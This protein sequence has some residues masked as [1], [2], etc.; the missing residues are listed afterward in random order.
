MRVRPLL[1]FAAI[2]AFLSMP[3]PLREAGARNAANP[4]PAARPSADLID[5]DDR[6]DVNNLD[7]VVTNHGSIAYDLITGNG[8]LVFPKGSAH[9]AVFAAGLWVGA[10]V[11]GGIRV[12]LGEYSQEYVPGPM[13][14]GTYL[15]DQDAF[16]NFRFTRG[17]PLTGSDLAEYVVQGGPTDASGQALLFGDAT[18]WSAFND[19]NP[20]M[21]TNRAGS[22]APL[23]IEVQ[24]TVFAFNRAGPLGNVIFV[25]WKLINKGG[26]RLDST[27]VS[28]WSDPDLGGFTDDLVGCDTTLSLGYCYN[29]TNTDGVYGSRPPA[30]GFELLRGVVVPRAPG[31]F[32]T[33]GMTSFIKY[34][35][36]TDPTSPEETYNYM[37][38]R[39]ADG[40]AMHVLI[41]SLPADPSPPVTL[42]AVSGLY[43]GAPRSS[44][45]WL[46]SNPGDRRMTL[47]S[48]PFTMAPG[49]SQEIVFAICIG[50]GS[51]RL[52]SIEDMRA[53]AATARAV[54]PLPP[55][56]PTLT[57]AVSID[58]QTIN[59]HS[60]APWVSATVEP[61]GFD[62][63]GI[64]LSS[65]LLAGALHAE[66]KF[67]TVGDHDSD[68]L[69]D[70]TLKFA[71]QGL[72]PLLVLGVNH[73]PLTGSLV[74]GEQFTGTA[75]VRVIDPFGPGLSARVSPNPLNPSG[76]L[77]FKT[78][79]SG[80][81]T[82]K[83]F[84]IRGRLVRSLMDVSFLPAG[85][86]EAEF[87]G[88]DDGGRAVASGIYIYEIETLEG[89]VAGRV[90]VLK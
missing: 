58:P 40:S 67:V 52:S 80:R 19:A 87:D 18:I 16:R 54:L 83:V 71:R 47:S 38:G 12:A 28:I 88:R 68:G 4:R 31:V 44:T 45:N 33:L 42:Y 62:P 24:Q 22:T 8:G 75:E 69:P 3:I 50:Q 34:V 36:G 86:H 85:L 77:A 76:V 60:R 27:Y 65:V 89:T 37:R 48:G 82:V 63:A 74:T 79:R 32:D 6:M 26:N 30:V 78:T 46:D 90:A 57:V 41:E 21:H 1:L 35:N 7:M 81:V 14:N 64:N 49:Q 2:A 84:D 5:N 53:K 73:L 55:P 70:V 17:A 43:P 25:K 39:N 20:D 56:P 13:A 66:P 23:G 72:D 15:T 61:F 10:K 29:A 51:D 59:L 9:T 11:N